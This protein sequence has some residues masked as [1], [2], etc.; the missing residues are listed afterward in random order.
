MALTATVI[1]LVTKLVNITIIHTSAIT[2][3]SLIAIFNS[4]KEVK[5]TR[6]KSARDPCVWNC[7][8]LKAASVPPFVILTPEKTEGSG[9][10]GKFERR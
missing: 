1:W 4:D 3:T 9:E 6:G 10:G 7:Q 2:K 8:D 5:L